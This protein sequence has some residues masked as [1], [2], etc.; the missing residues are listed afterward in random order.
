MFENLPK[1]KPS[2][3]L[4]RILICF[5]TSAGLYYVNIMPALVESLTN[6]LD[7]TNQQAGMVSSWNAYGS[8]LGAFLVIFFIKRLAW[9]SSSYL[10]LSL[11]VIVDLTSIFIETYFPLMAIRFIHGLVGGALIGIGFSII[12]K[13]DKPDK[14]FSILLL[15]QFMNSPYRL[16]RARPNDS[17]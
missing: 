17:P 10:L 8:A 7:F 15:V 6:H 2:S 14:T 5:L 1:T 13:T 16:W 4:N 12:A 3:M 9:R 11:L